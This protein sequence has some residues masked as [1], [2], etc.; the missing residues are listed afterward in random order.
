MLLLIFLFLSLHAQLPSNATV[1]AGKMGKGWNLGNALE[2]C[3][4]STSASETAW[5]TPKTTKALIDAVKAAG[6]TTVRIPA[7][8]SGYM[9]SSGKISSD[10]LAR[11]KEVVQ[12]VTNNSM[13]AILND[14]WD[15]GWLEENPVRSK[16]SEINA[17]L[18]NIWTQI[19]TYLK[20]FDE[21]LLFAGMNEVYGSGGS[22]SEYLEVQQ[23][24]LQTF[25]DAV[26]ATGGNNANRNLV[27]QALATNIE[28]AVNN[29]TIPKDS[30][31]GRLFVEVHYYDP[32][33]FAGDANSQIYLWG[34]DY[35]GNSHCS[36]WG[37]ED[38]VDEAFGKMSSSFVK[39]GYPV[40]LG[41]YGATYRGSLTGTALSDHLK[42][43]N[44]YA[45][46]V[47]QK[48]VANGIIPCYWDNGQLT[49][50]G[51]GIFDRNTYK[52]EFPDLLKAII[53]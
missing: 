7:A 41:E 25:V 29:L 46:Y 8:W 10:W 23:T 53:S 43:R 5:G 42:S 15:G 26:R 40:I 50:G 30:V 20:D 21:H 31:S 52:V 27:I 33:E 32:W 38:R 18:K 6:F 13:Y 9:D 37:Q 39:K 1:L 11:V 14:H 2:A 51:S 22:E 19:A 47:T 36:T 16:Q 45:Q 17:K 12:Y 34:K 49:T 44:Y 48:A 28:L 4:S 24:F 3:S 35:K